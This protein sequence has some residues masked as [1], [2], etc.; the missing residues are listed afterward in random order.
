MKILTRADVT[1]RFGRIFAEKCA[2]GGAAEEEAMRAKL[3]AA[4]LG[5]AVAATLPAAAE[6][7]S[8]KVSEAAAQTLVPT[9]RINQSL[10]ED[11]IRV[12]VNFHRCRAGL[13][14]VA[15]AG[16]GLTKQAQTHSRWMARA[17]KLSHK[18]SVA[19]A[20]TLKQR[21]KNSGIRFR[22]GSENIGMVHRY[23]IDNKRFKIVN[24]RSCQFATRGG[25]ILPAHSYATLARHVV[26]LWMKSKGHRKNILD[27][28]VSK[29]SAAV[30]FDPKNQFC[31]RFWVTQN[32]I[33]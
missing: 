9:G 17:Q 14:Q 19:G 12:E 16:N 32:F 4:C 6:A 2:T 26:D 24:A 1:P 21:I 31:G 5:L 11:A 10:L 29:M 23:R 18:N 7:C 33:G 30:A 15:D 28:R 20:S 22:T 3:V 8:R 27:N 13:P 25:E